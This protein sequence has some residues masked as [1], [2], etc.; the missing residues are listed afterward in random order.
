VHETLDP[1]GDS[2]SFKREDDSEII[3]IGH[4]TIYECEVLAGKE[5]RGLQRKKHFAEADSKLRKGLGTEPFSKY[6]FPGLIKIASATAPTKATCTISPNRELCDRIDSVFI[7]LPKF[8]Y[9]YWAQSK[10]YEPR[11]RIGVWPKSV[12]SIFEA[13][14]MMLFV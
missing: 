1:L 9:A 2:L 7:Y 3:N 4:C 11:M 13:G 12:N 14:L 5:L 6:V 10:T 8:L